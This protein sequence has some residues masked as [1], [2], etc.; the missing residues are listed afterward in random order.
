MVCI[1]LLSLAFRF[2]CSLFL[3]VLALKTRPHLHH[4]P[5]PKSHA[6]QRPHP[7]SVTHQIPAT[8]TVLFCTIFRFHELNS[9]GPLG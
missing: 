4:T 2:Q 8:T 3:Y 5:T 6:Q 7:Q 1:N 9:R